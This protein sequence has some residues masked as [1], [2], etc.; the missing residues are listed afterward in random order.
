MP[1]GLSK[2][3][4][5]SWMRVNPDLQTCRRKWRRGPAKHGD[6]RG[7]IRLQHTSPNG[8]GDNGP[9]GQ[10]TEFI[11]AKLIQM[12]L[13]LAF[14]TILLYFPPS[15]QPKFSTGPP[16]SMRRRVRD[17]SMYGWARRGPGQ[18]NG[19]RDVLNPV[20][21]RDGS[22]Q[23]PAAA[24][25]AASESAVDRM[26]MP[27]RPT[28]RPNWPGAAVS[29]ESGL[30]TTPSPAHHPCRQGGP[31]QA[32]TCRCSWNCS[33][34]P[35]PWRHWSEVNARPWRKP[36]DMSRLATSMA[37]TSRVRRP[38]RPVAAIQSN[39]EGN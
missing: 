10:F 26:S 7:L 20:P 16:C 2:S 22:P 15:S 18:Q 37:A 36:A 4:S 6:L 35:A 29:R 28:A 5:P 14:L 9:A 17:R 27:H 23:Q 11:E 1:N 33:G 3:R 39:P 19:S 21:D 24:A 12:Y 34:R 30:M 8:L 31:V 13:W 32:T 25:R 38:R